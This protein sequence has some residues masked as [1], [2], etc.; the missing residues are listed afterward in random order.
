[1]ED[2]GLYNIETGGPLA[3]LFILFIFEFRILLQLI[4]WMDN[5]GLTT[6]WSPLKTS[7]TK[8]YNPHSRGT[9]W[10][11]FRCDREHRQEQTPVSC[12]CPSSPA[13]A[14]WVSCRGS[15]PARG[16]IS[17]HIDPPACLDGRIYSLFSEPFAIRV[18]YPEFLQCS[19][20]FGRLRGWLAGLSNHVSNLLEATCQVSEL[21]AAAF[22]GEDHLS[23]PVD[24]IFVREGHLLP[25]GLCDLVGARQVEPDFG[26]GV[27]FVNVLAPRTTAPTV[28]Y[29]QAIDLQECHRCLALC[30][31][32]CAEPG[33]SSQASARFTPRRRHLAATMFPAYSF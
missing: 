3:C 32:V 27:H 18:F 17:V 16:M 14:T 25:H 8:A 13:A 2:I 24:L 12:W 31:P 30:R 7:V 4:Q 10:R 20:I 5:A 19:S 1:M 28:R 22:R 21:I 26:L 6:W 15:L 33:G 29:R 11:R 23:R 9:F